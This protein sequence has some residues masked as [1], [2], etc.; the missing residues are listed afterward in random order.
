MS[1]CC[2]QVVRRLGLPTVGVSFK[3]KLGI[4]D[5]QFFSK[6][7]ALVV[8]RL[9]KKVKLKYGINYCRFQLLLL[10]IS[11]SLRPKLKVFTPRHQVLL[12]GKLALELT[13][14][15]VSGN[16]EARQF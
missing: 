14:E 4:G 10:G 3:Y 8:R 11:V 9:K 2:I 16:R 15:N 12:Q 6:L 1:R 5:E 13:D 7:V